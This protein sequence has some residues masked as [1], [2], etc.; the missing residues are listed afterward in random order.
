[1]RDRF[2]HFPLQHFWGPLA[3]I[4]STQWIVASA[5]HAAAR[6]R[7]DYFYV[8]LPHLDYA[9][10]KL[11]PDSSA[12][13]EAVA[14]L[15]AAV[16][17]LA[18]GFAAAYDTDALL[19][20]VASEYVITPVDHVVYPNRRL[21][22]GGLLAVVEREDGEHLDLAGSPAW[23][24][25][26]HQLSHIFVR[27]REAAVIQ[28]VVE[29][30]TG[31]DGVARVLAGADRESLGMA[32]ERAGD[33][34]VI[35][36]PNTWQAYYWWLDDARAPAFARTVDIHRKPGYDPV[37]LHFDP[38]TKSTPLDAR[39]IRGS[40]GAPAVS[41]SQQGVLL[42]SRP[43]TIRRPRLR[44]IDLFDVVLLQLGGGG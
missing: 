27:G 29:L 24:L 12:A 41:A 15:D 13:T 4:Q 34:I 32:H 30:F 37:E 22:Q 43:D 20:L 38:L 1:L 10:Q 18:D 35:S 14:E 26:D 16:G 11:G 17:R 28:R 44:D 25:A 33:V 6:Y 7:P 21:R 39:L 23:A 36:T 9:A 40:H 8:Y 2:G 3:N 42:T 5:I 19:W 31:Q